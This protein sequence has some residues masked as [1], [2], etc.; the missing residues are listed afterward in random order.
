MYVVQNYA[1]MYKCVYTYTY[2]IQILAC[3]HAYVHMLFKVIYV[4]MYIPHTH[5]S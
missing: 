5:T 3:L 1:W 4:Y 2:I